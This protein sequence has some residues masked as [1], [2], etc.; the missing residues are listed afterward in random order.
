[1]SSR[2]TLDNKKIYEYVKQI[3]NHGL[4]NRDKCKFWGYN[5]RLDELQAAY[6]LIKLRHLEEFTKRYI[7]IA[8]LY[9]ENLSNKI[10]NELY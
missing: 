3:R 4:V 2:S 5:S 9:S 1:M 7:S 10:T 6:A 8:K